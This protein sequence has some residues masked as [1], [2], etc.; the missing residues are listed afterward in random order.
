MPEKNQKVIAICI[1]DINEDYNDTFLRAFCSLADSFH[2]KVL[3]FN[4]FSSLYYY[5]GHDIGE[6]NIFQLINY[7][8][9]D[10]MVILSQTI[11]TKKFAEEIAFTAQ[12]KGI[13]V[14]SIDRQI[15][16]CYNIDFDYDKA[17]EEILLHLIDIHHVR[18][19]NFIAGIKGN[20]YSESRLDIFR[21][22]LTDHNIPVEEDRI[23][24]G[25]FWADPTQKVLD[26][27]LASPLPFPEAIVCA[28]D[29]MAITA[30]N[31]LE[32]EGYHIPEDVL[33]TGFDGIQ[34]ALLHTPSITTSQHDLFG[35]AKKAFQI[36][37]DIFA[38]GH[39]Q[40]Q[41]W[42]NSKF[43]SGGSCGC[44]VHSRH[45]PNML[46]RE[47]YND[48]ETTK[49][50][51][52][53][54]IR[55]TADLSTKNS[56]QEVFDSIKEYT[57]EF[58]NHRFWLCIVDDYLTEEEFSDII[59]KSTIR[60][61]CYSSKMDLMLC[62]DHGQWQG[63]IDFETKNLLPNMES[64]WEETSNIIFLPLHVHEQTIGYAA[65]SFDEPLNLRHCY[66]FFMNISNSLEITKAHIRQQTIIQNLENKYVHDPLT[67]LFNRR[68][69]YQRVSEV[70]DNSI[71][72]QT[73]MMIISI[74]LN[75]LKPIND[76][77]GHADG[78]IAISTIARAL[79]ASAQR[80]DV[81]AR[82]GGDEFVVA[83]T[84][85]DEKEGEEY[86]ARVREYL[87]EFNRD[88]GRPYQISAS[89]GLIA[90][91]PNAQI[92][93]DEFIRQ[94]DEK[95]YAEKAKHHLSRSR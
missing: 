59:E 33:I 53:H 47:L 12:R 49:I 3:Y 48:I 32:A 66:Q 27:F 23:G 86:I 24:Y 42:I 19:F 85:S 78:D 17:L 13:P 55:M 67:G 44:G 11:K 39:P 83:G 50:Y 73:L 26:K 45:L 52:Q 77:Y 1:A 57:G 75:G 15:E 71:D 6:K 72:T 10:G 30:V 29:I 61:S 34:E 20:E 69:F 87:D 18:R 4:S 56:F 25:D 2:Y 38:G 14:V 89:F 5:E 31:R 92:T 70:Y 9:I 63:L 91:I 88:S 21:K 37:A 35:T 64:I 51:N 81:C 41:T 54:Q 58:L 28:N 68:G 40:K 7:D 60:R 94:A 80:D 43:L 90:A 93:L 36:L 8:I 16:N 74:D 22:V 82:F 76:T 65:L 79:L 46:M 95:M 62:Y 84:L